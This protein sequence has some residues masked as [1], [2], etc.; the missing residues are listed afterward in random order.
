MSCSITESESDS[1]N[2]ECG[3]NALAKNSKFALFLGFIKEFDKSLTEIKLKNILKF[4]LVKKKMHGKLLG[5]LPEY[6]V[7]EKKKILIVYK[8]FKSFT[9]YESPDIPIKVN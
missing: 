3:W 2:S 6:L 4:L 1:S 5:S 9:E 7:L 8:I